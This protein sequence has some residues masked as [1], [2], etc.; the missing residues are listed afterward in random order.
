MGILE[1]GAGLDDAR[2]GFFDVRGVN[3]L[4]PRD[5]L[6][7]VGDQRR[8]VEGNRRDGPAEPG[9]ILDLEMNMR[10]DH[11]E[12]LGHAAADHAG[13]AHPV[14]FGHHHPGTMTGSDAGGAHATAYH[15]GAALPVFCAPHPPGTMPGSDAGG[16]HATGPP[17]DHEQVDVEISHLLPAPCEVSLQISL[18]RFFISMR[19]CSLTVWA[20]TCA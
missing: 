18:P 17:A 8:P 19:N 4:Q 1:R 15:A 3:P 14:F 6:I 11:Q 16:A 5:L 9:R 10:R 13:A 20:N 7:L 12:L 2:A